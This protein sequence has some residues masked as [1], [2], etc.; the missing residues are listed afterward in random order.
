MICLSG[1]TLWGRGRLAERLGEFYVLLKVSSLQHSWNLS[2]PNLAETYATSLVSSLNRRLSSATN[3]MMN[4]FILCD[5]D[6]SLSRFFRQARGF[7]GWSASSKASSERTFERSV[8]ERT[9]SLLSIF[10][11]KYSARD[12]SVISK[13]ESAIRSS[14]LTS[15]TYTLISLSRLLL[16]DSQRVPPASTNLRN[17][18]GDLLPDEQVLK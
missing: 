6:K 5:G 3:A 8:R 14:T 2:K 9:V 11:S 10:A 12:L 17:L 7:L 18:S 1:D 15:R 13:S 4:S 16:C